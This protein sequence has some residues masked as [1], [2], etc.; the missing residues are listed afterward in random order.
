MFSVPY[1]SKVL[2]AMRQE[3]GIQASFNTDLVEVNT[4]DKVAVFKETGGEKRTIEKAFDMMWVPWCFSIS[5]T[6]P[7]RASG[8]ATSP[9]PWVH[10]TR[11][12][13]LR[14]PTLPAG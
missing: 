2:D 11:S 13:R 10:S 4:K 12:R 14:L 5:R 7:D 6:M 8:A 3:R 9:H 1:Y